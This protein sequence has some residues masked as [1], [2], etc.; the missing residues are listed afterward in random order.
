MVGGLDGVPP[1]VIRIRALAVVALVAACER[2]SSEMEGGRSIV[3]DSAIRA[4]PGYVVDSALPPAESLRRFRV[5]VD[6]VSGLDGP[7]SREALVR[8]FL[9]ALEQRDARALR[10]L[11]VSRA[12]YAWVVF[13]NSRLSLPP[14]QHPPDVAWLMLQSSSSTGFN[15]VLQRLGG[16]QATYTGYQCDAPVLD[17]RV[18]LHRNCRV[19]VSVAGEFTNRKLF[20]TI[21]E[22]AGRYKFLSYD[23]DF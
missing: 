5:G 21:V 11:G 20:G 6:S 8:R 12:E 15:R 17:G 4:R 16:G 19:R 2:P 7:T 22:H 14:Y 1:A 13:P 9:A 18:R 23:T 10:S 3:S